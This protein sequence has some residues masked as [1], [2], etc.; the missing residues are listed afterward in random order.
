[1]LYEMHVKIN[2]GGAQDGEKGKRRKDVGGY[3]GGKKKTLPNIGEKERDRAS[4]QSNGDVRGSGRQSRKGGLHN[5]AF[6]SSVG[7]LFMA[8]EKKRKRA[9]REK[10]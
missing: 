3:R 9:E 2:R 4:I 10:E 5:G 6:K 8:A 7:V 1:M